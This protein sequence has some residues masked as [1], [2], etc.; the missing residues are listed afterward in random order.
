MEKK[1]MWQKDVEKTRSCK[2]TNVEE[3][4]SEVSTMSGSCR[5]VELFSQF[6]GSLECPPQHGSG[7]TLKI[8]SKRHN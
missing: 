3:E 1:D 7:V 4:E 5:V 6:I 8:T 2:Q